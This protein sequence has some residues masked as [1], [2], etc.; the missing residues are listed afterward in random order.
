MKILPKSKKEEYIPKIVVVPSDKDIQQCAEEFNNLLGLKCLGMRICS[1]QEAMEQGLPL[2]KAMEDYN[3]KIPND[4]YVA[5]GADELIPD[6]YFDPT[7]PVDI[8]KVKFK[9]D[10]I[11][12]EVEIGIQTQGRNEPCACGS[13]KKYKKCC[14][15]KGKALQKGLTIL[16]LCVSLFSCNKETNDE[17][18]IIKDA[19]NSSISIT[20]IDEC[21]YVLYSRYKHGASVIHKKNC[22]NKIHNK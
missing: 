1:L 18:V 22:K 11:E 2:K 6:G 21:E 19:A 14:V 4:I 13:G 7:E 16:L 17:G 12:A 3:N 15:K 8:D 9:S 5:A 10:I 20:I